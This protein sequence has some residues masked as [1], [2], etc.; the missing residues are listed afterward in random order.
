MLFTF[1]KKNNH[2][3]I[4]VKKIIAFKTTSC[5][6]PSTTRVLDKEIKL[7]WHFK[8]ENQGGGTVKSKR[9]QEWRT[10]YLTDS[11]T[12]SKVVGEM[13]ASL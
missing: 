4:S 2:I 6:A 13:L 9:A 3:D 8:K 12:A 5:S 7:V 11:A 10:L 1:L